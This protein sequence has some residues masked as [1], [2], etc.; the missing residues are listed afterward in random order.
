MKMGTIAS[1]WRY[2]GGAYHALKTENMRPPAIW[3]C[4]HR[5]QF[6]DIAVVRIRERRTIRESGK[7]PLSEETRKNYALLRAVHMRK[8]IN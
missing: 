4:A 3:R 1:P 2:D 6:Y 7:C 8:W 5:G